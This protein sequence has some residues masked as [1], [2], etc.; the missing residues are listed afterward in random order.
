[1]HSPRPASLLFA[2]ALA[3]TAWPCGAQAIVLEAPPGVQSLNYC[4]NYHRIGSC[5]TVHVETEA[6]V[7][8]GSFL[9]LDGQS[10]VIEWMGP[11]FYL[12]SGVIL[13]PLGDAAAGLKGQRWLEVYP[14]QGKI[15]RS[16][17]WRDRDRNK[18]LSSQDTLIL[19]G[20][21]FKVKDVRFHVRVRPAGEDAPELQRE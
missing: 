13:E 20:R 17:G 6:A 14:S 4:D 2:L 21:A 1:M 3:C 7:T 11:G 5:T 12:D 19:N 18:A 16:R 8:V 9:K 10:Y 15:H